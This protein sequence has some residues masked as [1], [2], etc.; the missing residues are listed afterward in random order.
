MMY[1]DWH[2]GKKDGGEG[3]GIPKAAQGWATRMEAA[4][5]GVGGLAEN[6]WIVE[7]FL[8]QKKG[9]VKRKWNNDQQ[10]ASVV[11]FIFCLVVGCVVKEAASPRGDASPTPKQKVRR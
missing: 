5:D 11:G 4:Q 9:N 3:K 7:G 2:R 1:E 10:P 6:L 8:E